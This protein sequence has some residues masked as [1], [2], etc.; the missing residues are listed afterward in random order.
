MTERTKIEY[1]Q[2]GECTGEVY[3]NGE[4]VRASSFRFEHKH[5][6][7]PKAIIEIVDPD[8]VMS[9]IDCTVVKKTKLNKLKSLFCYKK[10]GDM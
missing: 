4:K 5:T 1:R 6:N 9:T 7:I 3:V 2:T 8:V 10:K